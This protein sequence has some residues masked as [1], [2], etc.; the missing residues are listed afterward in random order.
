MY[1][2]SELKIMTGEELFDPDPSFHTETQTTLREHVFRQISQSLTQGQSFNGD[3]IYRTFHTYCNTLLTH[4]F[5][6]QHRVL[7]KAHP[8]RLAKPSHVDID[9]AGEFSYALSRL[10]AREDFDFFSGA[11]IHFTDD[12]DTFMS[13]PNISRADSRG[14]LYTTS[15]N[16]DG[17]KHLTYLIRRPDNNS[18]PTDTLE[19]LSL[20]AVTELAKKKIRRKTRIRNDQVI[21]YNG[22]SYPVQKK[23]GTVKRVTPYKDE[24]AK[25]T[26]RNWSYLDVGLWAHTSHLHLSPGDLP[27][28]DLEHPPTLEKTAVYSS[29][30]QVKEQLSTLG[31][32]ADGAI[33]GNDYTFT[34]TVATGLLTPAEL[35]QLANDPSVPDP[36][37]SLNGTIKPEQLTEPERDLVRRFGYLQYLNRYQGSDNRYQ[38]I[39][40]KLRDLYNQF[41]I[42]LLKATDSALGDNVSLLDFATLSDELIANIPVESVRNLLTKA[43]HDHRKILN[44]CY[45]LGDNTYTLTK[46]IHHIFGFTDLGFFG[47][48]G[49]TLDYLG[50]ES[51]YSGAKVGRI[52]LPE[53]SVNNNNHAQAIQFV[54]ALSKSDIQIIQTADETEV[55][56]QVNGVILQTLE[57]IKHLRDLLSRGDIQ[58]RDEADQTIN[59]K[60]I[61]ILLDMESRHLQQACQECGILAYICYYTS[62]NTRVPPIQTD[63]THQETIV[64]SLGERGSLAVLLSGLSVLHGLVYRPH[65]PTTSTT[66]QSGT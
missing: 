4:D 52:V 47:K 6:R 58:I 60:K 41:Q 1:N 62:D 13:Q 21:G 31:L 48:V 7:D 5:A 38:A 51:T 20:L 61:K 22:R 39:K 55:I 19:L 37:D 14:R 28:S 66:H 36:L 9:V 46:S 12:Y 44:F 18:T 45:P 40:A 32:S 63:R 25:F 29:T 24:L 11:Q 42:P 26:G 3:Q 65:Q 50:N 54:N 23:D 10:I 8:E 43:K 56:L 53:K 33:L 57:D 16:P 17:S 30:L 49:S 2:I 35:N 15:I 27:L 59:P 34:L 64:T